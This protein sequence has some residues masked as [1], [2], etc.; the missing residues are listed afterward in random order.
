MG[1]LRKSTNLQYFPSI[2]LTLHGINFPRYQFTIH[3]VLI[4]YAHTHSTIQLLVCVSIPLSTQPRIPIY[5]LGSM[6]SCFNFH[7]LLKEYSSHVFLFLKHSLIKCQ[8]YT[9][10]STLKRTFPMCT[11]QCINYVS[12]LN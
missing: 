11:V 6:Y 9:F 10:S 2:F 12:T 8:L 7:Q 3:K 5:Q 4:D 1:N